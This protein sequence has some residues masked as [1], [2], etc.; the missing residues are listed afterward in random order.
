V[1]LTQAQLQ[2]DSLQW[3][4]ALA[5]LKHLNSLNPQHPYILKLLSKAYS[6][7]KDWEQLQILLPA[8]QKTDVLSEKELEGLERS[9]Y[10]VLLVKSAQK[11]KD[12]LLQQW[13]AIP[14]K[15]QLSPALLEN[16]TKFLIDCGETERAIAL[17]EAS[18]KKHWNPKLVEYYGL[19]QG[20]HPVKQLLTAENWLKQH[21]Q[22]PELLLC[23]G[24]LSMQGKFFGK[25]KE[26][27]QE[28]LKYAPLQS[29]VYKTLGEVQEALGD[30][31]AALECYRK[32]LGAW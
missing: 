29:V 23:L 5:T 28:A 14:K 7:L 27:L 18:L 15:W 20:D 4:Q 22:E 2:M 19:A 26:Y 24:R 6:Q 13:Q 21:P 32:G 17:I 16:Y 25:A 12:S 31:R 8:L 1:G 3:E 9:I 11:G 30:T 10:Q